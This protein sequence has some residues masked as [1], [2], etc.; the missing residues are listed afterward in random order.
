MTVVLALAVVALVGVPVTVLAGLV[1]SYHL[2]TL[3]R[4]LRSTTT[5]TARALHAVYRAAL[6]AAAPPP[7]SS[8]VQRGGLGL[9]N[10]PSHRKEQ[11]CSSRRSPG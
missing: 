3:L 2:V 7:S 1:D 6:T 9:P 4:V 8:T 11:S 5:V 10:A